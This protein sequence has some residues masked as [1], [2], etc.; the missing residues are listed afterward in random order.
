MDSYQTALGWVLSKILQLTMPDLL[1]ARALL[2]LGIPTAVVGYQLG[3]ALSA[4]TQ[5][6]IAL[7]MPTLQRESLPVNDL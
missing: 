7:T 5:D 2:D 1:V 4:F 6:H 3:T